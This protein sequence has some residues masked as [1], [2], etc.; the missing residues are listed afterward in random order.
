MGALAGAAPALRALVE[1]AQP[2]SRWPVHTIDP[3]APWVI[4]GRLALIGDAAHAM[5]PYAAQGAAMAIEDAVT[6][7][8]SV[9]V[10]AEGD[11]QAALQSWEAG[12]RLRMRAV[13]RRGALNHLAWRAGGPVALL[14]DQV[15]RRR[16]PARLAADLD[17][18]YGW[19]P[20]GS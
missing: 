10:G 7:A 12:R 6:L 18:I 8:N 14:R 9:V 3:R 1:E 20:E 11:Q 15:L 5:T 2:W 16:G 13:A 19:R 17:P 4:G